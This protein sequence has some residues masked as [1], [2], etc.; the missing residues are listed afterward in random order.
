MIDSPAAIIAQLLVDLDA[1]FYPTNLTP[2]QPTQWPVYIASVPDGEG[3]R[4]NAIGIYDTVGYKDGRIMRTGENVE[5]PGWQI[6]ARS[7]S[8]STGFDKVAEIGELLQ[9]V[10]NHQIALDAQSGQINSYLVHNIT[11]TNSVF[12][13]GLDSNDRKRRY[14]FT[15]NG[16]ITLSRVESI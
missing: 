3:V 13:L 1:V 11:R 10:R 2:Q 16:T 5:Y 6:M 14:A 9:D 12:P 8:Y 4:D 7:I 15:I